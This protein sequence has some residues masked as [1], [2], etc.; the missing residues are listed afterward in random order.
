MN[1]DFGK[2]R[3]NFYKLL[4]QGKFRTASLF[5]VDIIYFALEATSFNLFARANNEDLISMSKKNLSS[6]YCT[7]NMFKNL[8]I[9]DTCFVLGCLS[10]SDFCLL[11]T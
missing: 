3:Y 8:C 10:Q 11:L 6:M 4:S 7:S 1:C 5:R 2:F 9:K